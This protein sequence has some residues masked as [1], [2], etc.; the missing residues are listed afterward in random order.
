MITYLKEAQIRLNYTVALKQASDLEQAAASLETKICGT[1]SQSVDQLSS[2]WK[3][4]SARQFIRKEDELGQQIQNTA[5]Q[6]RA[7]ARTV[8]IVARNVYNTEMQNLRI[9]RMMMMGL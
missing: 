7:A 3:G 8:R 4:E 1:I 6:L 9:A 5:S 2:D